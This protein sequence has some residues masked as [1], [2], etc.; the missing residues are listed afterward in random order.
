VDVSRS[1]TTPRVVATPAALEAIRR[2]QTVRGPLMLFQSGGCCDGSLPICFDGGELLI[3][4][5]DVLL[6]T[7]GDCPFYIDSRQ[8]EVWKHTQLIL[9]VSPGLP[10]GFSLAASDAEH[11]IT[12]SRVF[13][14]DERALLTNT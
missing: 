8:H 6:G 7:V 1:A 10:E 9:D 14:V 4:D 2:L 3:G 11:F 5:G 13:S 12:R